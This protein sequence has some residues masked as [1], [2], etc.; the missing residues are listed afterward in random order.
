MS[1]FAVAND[2]GPC[3]LPL[4]VSCHDDEAKEAY[5]KR[6]KAHRRRVRASLW[7][8]DKGLALLSSDA[9]VRYCMMVHCTRTQTSAVFS[10]HVFSICH[11]VAD[12]VFEP[13]TQPLHMCVSMC[14][15]ARVVDDT[16]RCSPAI[17]FFLAQVIEE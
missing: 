16:T 9:I 5:E 7:V 15:S 8:R 3:L 4:R 11:P 1:Y 10:P 14:I 2:A 6:Q 13:I 12:G 17:T